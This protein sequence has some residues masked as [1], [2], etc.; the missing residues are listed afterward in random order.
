LRFPDGDVEYRSTR[1]ELPVGTHVRSSGS[2]WRVREFSGSAAILEPVESDDL[3][4]AAG[5]SA[6][7]P[8]PLGDQP[9]TFEIL[10]E[11]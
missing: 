11:A 4:G 9:L 10:I 1:G 2:V 7:T 8:G 3:T 6:I 5:G